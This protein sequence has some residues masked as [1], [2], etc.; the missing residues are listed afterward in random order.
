MGRR[1]SAM[2]NSLVLPREEEGDGDSDSFVS[3]QDSPSALQRQ[4]LE[5]KLRAKKQKQAE[6][7]FAQLKKEKNQQKVGKEFGDLADMRSSDPVLLGKAIRGLRKSIL[8]DSKPASKKNDTI[9]EDYFHRNQAHTP[10]QQLPPVNLIE[11]E[12]P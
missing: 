5:Q 2:R 12:L 1:P 6:K 7:K 8:G 10:H 11:E 3:A 9:V 4:L